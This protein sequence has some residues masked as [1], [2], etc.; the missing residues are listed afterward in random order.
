MGLGA[1]VGRLDRYFWRGAGPGRGKC[2]VCGSE[3]FAPTDCIIKV[4]RKFDSLYGKG[5]LVWK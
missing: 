5:G 4:D 3:V 2:L 1:F